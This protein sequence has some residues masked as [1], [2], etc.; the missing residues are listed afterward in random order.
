M[1]VSGIRTAEAQNG[2]ATKQASG[3][4]VCTCIRARRA[5]LPSA[6]RRGAALTLRIVRC[7]TPG[8]RART[9]GADQHTLCMSIFM[10]MPSPL[11][12]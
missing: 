12:C 5:E 7:C 3:T 11:K 2:R 10:Q 8:I 4:H 1:R 6:A 9:S